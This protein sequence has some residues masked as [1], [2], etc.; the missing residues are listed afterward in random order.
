VLAVSIKTTSYSSAISMI[1]SA[2]LATVEFYTN[3]VWERQRNRLL[4]VGLRVIGHVA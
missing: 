1:D 2:A 4:H 3:W